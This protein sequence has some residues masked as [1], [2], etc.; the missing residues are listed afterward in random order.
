[1]RTGGVTLAGEVPHDR[2][3]A[4]YASAD[5][6]V[7]PSSTDTQALVLHEAAHTGLP[8]VLVDPGLRLV[9]DE[10]VNA[11]FAAPEP[12]ALGRTILDFLTDLRDPDTAST[13]RRRSRELAARFTGERQGA[14][15][16]ELYASLVRR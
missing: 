8:L 5:L 6:F 11:P 9:A 4:Y 1:M 15:M 10:G 7:F 2:L 12:A 3:G 16:G 13:A 14:E